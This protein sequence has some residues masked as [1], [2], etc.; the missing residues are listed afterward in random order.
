MTIPI[1]DTSGFDSR[2]SINVFID[3]AGASPPR[4]VSPE[5]RAHLQAEKE[6]L[7]R[8]LEQA[9]KESGNP[10]LTWQPSESTVVV[11]VTGVQTSRPVP[12]ERRAFLIA[13]KERVKRL[14]EEHRKQSEQQPDGP[15][16]PS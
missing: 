9:R 14:L 1:N 7:E 10:N 6:R 11:D 13:E 15:S 5:R 16:D 8:L 2:D 3:G 4:P 12:A